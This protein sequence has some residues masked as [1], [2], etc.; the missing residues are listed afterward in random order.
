MGK[1]DLEKV[2]KKICIEDYTTHEYVEFLK[3]FK[4][5]NLIIRFFENNKIKTIRVRIDYTQLPHLIGFHYAYEKESNKYKYYGKLAI[6]SFDK[7]SFKEIARNVE[8]NKIRM[9]SNANSRIIKWETDIKPRFEYLPF[10]LN[11]IC[12]KYSLKKQEDNEDIRLV[13]TKLKGKYFYYKFTNKD[14]LIFSLLKTKRSYTFESFIVNDGL[15]FL[16]TLDTLEVIDV[17]L[18]KTKV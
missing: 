5:K 16:G 9:G 6:E 13:K 15:R 10:A 2:N 7:L 1:I 18:E 8:K 14:Y 17:S 11:T 4:E 12:S 3:S